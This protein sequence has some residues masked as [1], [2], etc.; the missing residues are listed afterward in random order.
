MALLSIFIGMF[1]SAAVLCL[2]LDCWVVK[3]GAL[4]AAFISSLLGF[5]AM[6]VSYILMAEI[7]DRRK[8]SKE[9]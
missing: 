1:Y 6:V 9:P 8:K 2:N 3:F 4:G 7:R 5:V